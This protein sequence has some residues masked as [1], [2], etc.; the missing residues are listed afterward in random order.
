MKDQF[1]NKSVENW[2]AQNL[3]KASFQWNS[4]G[5]WIHSYC[6]SK[7]QEDES[8]GYRDLSQVSQMQGSVQP[9]EDWNWILKTI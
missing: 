9:N 6:W 5:R 1:S 3:W 2:S 7:Q 8:G 4:I